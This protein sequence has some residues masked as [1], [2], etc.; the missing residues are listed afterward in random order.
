MTTSAKRALVLGVTNGA[1]IGYGT[2]MA[3]LE[4]G[5]EVI[6]AT[7]PSLV[8]KAEKALPNGLPVYPCNVENDEDIAAL[9]DRVGHVW[10]E[11]FDYL[12]HAIAYSDPEELKGSIFNTSRAN[13]L[14]T[15]DI[16]AYSFL[17]LC[18]EFAPLLR[19][20]GSVACYTFAASRY[21]SPN[22]NTMAMAKAALEAMVKYIAFDPL[23]GPRRITV[24]AISAGPV[25]TISLM[26]VGGSRTSLQMG[27]RRSATGENVTNLEVGKATLAIMQGG[28]FTGGTHDADNGIACCGMGAGD[29]E[30]AFNEQHGKANPA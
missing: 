1:S 15:Q 19:E 13:Y 22:Y 11:G 18:R 24:N 2:V 23:F 28:I 27:K 4:A 14:R 21:R 8:S 29:A 30:Y 9:K 25:K 17:A 6:V 26:G 16:S 12:V 3:M 20:G 7:L 5:I 10:H